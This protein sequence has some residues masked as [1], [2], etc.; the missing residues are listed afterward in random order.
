[1]ELTIGSS[2]IRDANGS[3]V[4]EGKEQLFLEW[5]QLGG[6][7]LLTMNLYSPDGKH[8]ARLRRNDW[9]FNDHEQFALTTKRKALKLVD[10]RTGR[11]ALEARTVGE[12]KV[13]IRDGAF[14]SQK[15]NQVE[16]TAAF[17]RIEGSLSGEE[18][19]EVAGGTVQIG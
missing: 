12:D 9:T 4:V 16:I 14:F 17:C 10:T 18:P 3:I 11:T 6:E 13:E 15:G 19:V 2:I 7:L 5:G 1:M 8:V